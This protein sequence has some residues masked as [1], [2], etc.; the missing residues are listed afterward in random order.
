MILDNIFFQ[1][2][3][4]AQSFVIVVVDRPMQALYFV[5]DTNPVFRWT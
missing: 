2:S 5:A 1:K 4:L 3:G